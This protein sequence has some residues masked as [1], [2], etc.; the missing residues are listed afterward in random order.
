VNQKVNIYQR[1]EEPLPNRYF[2]IS[3][4]KSIIEIIRLMIDVASAMRANAIRA[5]FFFYA[6][7]FTDMSS[8]PY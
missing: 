3:F 5:C 1:E 8:F 6:F 4:I 7:F 2:L